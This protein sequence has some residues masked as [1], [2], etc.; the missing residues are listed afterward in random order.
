MMH[1]LTNL[2]IGD[3]DCLSAAPLLLVWETSIRSYAEIIGNK[4]AITEILQ[5][6]AKQFT[7]SVEEA[8][9]KS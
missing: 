7:S 6:A 8:W 1:G 3:Q 4:P 2:K 9:A 5:V